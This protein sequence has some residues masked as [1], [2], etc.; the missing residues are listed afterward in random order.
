M[1]VFVYSRLTTVECAMVNCVCG[2]F[3]KAPCPPSSLMFKDFQ[4]YAARRGLTEYN[5]MA[6]AQRCKLHMTSS[7][8]GRTTRRDRTAES[9]QAEKLNMAVVSVLPLFGLL[10]V[11]VL[12]FVTITW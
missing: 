12:L 5:I 6:I 7:N 1:D 2:I 8:F 10:L 11:A 4:S 9:F 3:P